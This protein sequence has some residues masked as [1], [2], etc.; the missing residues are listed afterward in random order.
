MTA[1]VTDRADRGKP[2]TWIEIGSIAGPTAQIPSAALRAARLTIV[3][4]GQGSVR[5]HEY[6][7]ELPALAGAISAGELDVDARAVPLADVEQAW[8]ATDATHRVV[9]TPQP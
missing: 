1:V 8:A 3:G 9:L 5:V 6:L 4:S 2:L 7:A